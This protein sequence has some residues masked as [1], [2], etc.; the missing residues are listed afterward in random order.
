MQID[1]YSFG[2]I[3]SKYNEFEEDKITVGGFHQKQENV[4]GRLS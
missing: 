4:W 3:I 1:S 2:E